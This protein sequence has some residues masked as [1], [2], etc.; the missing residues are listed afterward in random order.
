MYGEVGVDV[1]QENDDDVD[2]LDVAI[3]VAD[4]E[5]SVNTEPMPTIND[6]FRNTLAD[7]TEDNDGISQLLRNVETGCLSERELR[8]LEKMRQDGKTPLYKNCPMSKLEANIMLLEFKSTNGL[9]DKGFDQ[10]LDIIRKLLP[11][12]NEL[13]E[14]TYLAKQ[15]IYPI[16]L[17]VE[18]I[19]ACSNDCILYHEEKCKDLDKCPKCEA[20]CYKE[21]LSDEGT[22][23]RGGPVKVV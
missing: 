23:T 13:P 15:M 17:E 22:K 10:L 19:H 16:G 21:G 3:H 4:E 18:K 8:K 6:V 5:P 12:D 7:D 20:P 2:M 1:P 14:K 11:E 9:S